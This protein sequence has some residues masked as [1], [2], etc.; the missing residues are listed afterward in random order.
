MS[1]LADRGW[2]DVVL[3]FFVFQWGSSGLWA[4]IAPRSFYDSFPGGGRSWVS[5]D[6][7][8]NEHLVRDV[9]GLF[10]ALAAVSV[11][12]LI[13]RTPTMVRTAGIALLVS[14]APHAIYHAFNSDV[15][16]TGDAIA[17]VGGLV[18]GAGLAALL[19]ASP[20]DQT[21]P[22]MRPPK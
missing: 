6:G 9:G 18:L 19:V 3:A 4:L 11:V 21:Q 17:S 5:V 15:L 12:A 10:L 20:G 2:R 7:P 22:A 16:S 14:G 1:R 8:Y 13:V